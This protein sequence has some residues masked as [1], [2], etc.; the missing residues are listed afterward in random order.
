MLQNKYIGIQIVIFFFLN[1]QYKYSFFPHSNSYFNNQELIQIEEVHDSLYLKV[2]YL[3]TLKKKWLS[4]KLLIYNT[5]FKF[6][7]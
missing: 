2:L 4:N 5:N 3:K 7:Y 6:K 1:N